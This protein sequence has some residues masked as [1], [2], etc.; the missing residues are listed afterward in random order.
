MRCVAM[1]HASIP[2]AQRPAPLIRAPRDLFTV[3]RARAW[4]A[5]AV[6]INRFLAAHAFASWVAY[7]GRGLGAMIR[8]LR[9]VLA[10]LRYEVL[11]ACEQSPDTLSDALLKDAIRRSDLLLVHLAD[12]GYSQED[13]EDREGRKSTGR[14]ERSGSG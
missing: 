9:L 2:Q 13:Q 1:V 14:S 7:Q 4:R 12:R 10:V 3:D 6:V 11:R 8:G 5:H